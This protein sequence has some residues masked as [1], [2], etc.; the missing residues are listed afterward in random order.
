MPGRMYNI[1]V[2]LEALKKAKFMRLNDEDGDPKEE[3]FSVSIIEASD[4]SCHVLMSFEDPN[5]EDEAAEIDFFLSEFVQ[6]A[7]SVI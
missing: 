5:R 1:D 3:I 4:S 2:V 6:G 7:Y